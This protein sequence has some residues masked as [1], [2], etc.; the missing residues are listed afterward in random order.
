MSCKVYTSNF[1][2][3]SGICWRKEGANLIFCLFKTGTFPGRRDRFLKRRD[4]S[5]H[6]NKSLRVKNNYLIV[7]A[8]FLFDS[9]IPEEGVFC[10]GVIFETVDRR[11]WRGGKVETWLV[12]VATSRTPFSPGRGRISAAV[13]T[14]RH[15]V[16]E[17]TWFI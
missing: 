6:P 9:V 8:F 15:L 12:L 3:Q 13:A 11:M 5:W 17:H 2:T 14:F 16:E 1:F 10:P 7:L 4:M